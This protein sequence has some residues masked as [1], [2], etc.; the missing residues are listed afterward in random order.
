MPFNPTKYY[1]ERYQNDKAFR[2]LRKI[3]IKK[4][5]QKYPFRTWAQHTLSSHKRKG[6]IVTLT[7]EQIE[8]IAIKIISC[9]LCN[10][11]LTYSKEFSD[12]S[13]SL[14]RIDNDKS[15]SI[16]NAQILCY[17]CNNAKRTM[18]MNEFKI[19]ITKVY[20]KL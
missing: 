14:D 6:I 5:Q 9:P 2:E 13:A 16:D 7:R 17:R 8:N 4:S 19:W 1:R 15:L 11:T 10:C 20:F 3:S 12:C 18:S